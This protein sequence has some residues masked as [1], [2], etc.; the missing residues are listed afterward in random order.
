MTVA[1]V[2]LSDRLPSLPIPLSAGTS[3]S[4]DLQPVLDRCYD[5]GLYARRVHYADPCDPPLTADQQAWAEGILRA[6][7]LRA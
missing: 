6:R 4:I 3:V 7:G 5:A 1:P 2:R